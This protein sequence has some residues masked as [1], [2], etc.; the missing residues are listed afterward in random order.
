MK[1]LGGVSAKFEGLG[2]TKIE[3]IA[4]LGQLIGQLSYEIPNGQYSG[5]EVMECVAKNV[6]TGNSQRAGD[7]ALLGVN[8][9]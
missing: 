8:G 6:I 7:A 9:G 1:E 2:I 3:Q 5:A 4:L